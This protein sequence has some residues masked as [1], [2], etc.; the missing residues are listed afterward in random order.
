MLIDFVINRYPPSQGGAEFYA[1]SLAEHLAQKGHR[2]NVF[3]SRLRSNYDREMIDEIPET[4]E[5]G[6]LRIRRF[7]PAFITRTDNYP[8]FPKMIRDLLSSSSDIIHGHSLYYFS[9]DISGGI[10]KFRSKPFVLSPYFAYR[11]KPRWSLL[12]NSVNRRILSAG[13]VA[14]LTEYEKI[15]IERYFR[16]VRRFETVPP[17]VAIEEFDSVSHNVL[18]NFLEN[19]QHRVLL[20]AG[21]LDKGKGVDVLLRAM[22]AILKNEPDTI[23]CI[24]G[25]DFGEL[26][27]LK[28]LCRDLKISGCVFFLGKLSRPDLCSAFVHAD[29]FVFPSRYEAFGIVLIEAMAARTPVVAARSSAIPWVVED[30]VDGLLFEP[31]NPEDLALKVSGTLKN[32][33]ETQCRVRQGRQKVER[34]YSWP[35]ITDK[36]EQIYLSLLE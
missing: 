13:V 20:F 33:R 12:R 4:E 26:N 25:E 36:L 2:I 3:S 29:V 1:Q 19:R 14:V 24:A 5:K 11:P 27:N 21:R 15:E 35:V 32:D 30:G 34:L 9:A 16:G 17:G 23:C 7:P 10:S 18:E 28:S 31:E 8:I 22:P 6:R